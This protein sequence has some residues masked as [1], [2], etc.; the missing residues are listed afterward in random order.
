LNTAIE[1]ICQDE[2]PLRISR[3]LVIQAS[4]GDDQAHGLQIAGDLVSSLSTKPS[5]QNDPTVSQIPYGPIS[6]GQETNLYEQYN[7]HDAIT[8]QN[9]T[10][11]TVDTS[12]SPNA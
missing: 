9:H 11:L 7:L 4:T 3:N 1:A 2:A 5:E 8:P 10:H 12:E 6:F